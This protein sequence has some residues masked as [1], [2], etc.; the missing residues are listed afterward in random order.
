MREPGVA[1][2]AVE[3]RCHGGGVADHEP[4]Q[5]RRLVR[6][7]GRDSG[8]Q[9]GADLPGGVLRERR[10]RDD[11]HRLGDQG[12]R[13]SVQRVGR[14]HPR[15]HPQHG[16]REETVDVARR[17]DSHR[18]VDRPAPSPGRLDPERVGVELPLV[19]GA[20]GPGRVP[21]PPLGIRRDD[22]VGL[23]D[24][25]RADDGGE[26]A[27]D[28]RLDPPGHDSGHHQ[29]ERSGSEEDATR[30]RSA[31]G[32]VEPAHEQQRHA[33]RGQHEAPPSGDT[34]AHSP[35]QGRGTDCPADHSGAKTHV[36]PA[37]AARAARTCGRRCPTPPAAGPRTRTCRSPRATPRSGRPAPAPRRA[38]SRGRRRSP[39]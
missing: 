20:A 26:R 5:K 34:D 25:T 7:A 3:I 8:A 14:E 1:H 36:R 37:R 35:G 15:A 28:E 6:G 17:Q 2:R 9:G 38:A 29:P 12:R 21:E 22:D 31:S 19:V 32:S 13:P 24:R 16:P 18:E 27:V 11:L 33:Q 23:D 4:R 30:R 39:C 10:T